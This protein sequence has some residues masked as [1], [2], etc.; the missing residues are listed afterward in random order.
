MFAIR[1]GTMSLLTTY[2]NNHAAYREDPESEDLAELHAVLSS[3]K[4]MAS[5]LCIES[6]QVI[7]DICGRFSVYNN[8]ALSRIRYNQDI[9]VTWEGDNTVLI[10]Q[11]GKYA[12]KHIQRSFKGHPVNSKVLAE[13]FIQGQEFLGI[14]CSI[15]SDFTDISDDLLNGIKYKFNYYLYKSI[16]RLQEKAEKAEN[17]MEAW[18][19]SQ[20]YYIQ[21]L[22][23]AFG[24]Y[25]MATGLFSYCKEVE[26]GCSVTGKE[27]RKVAN[28]FC[29]DRIISS[30]AIFQEK[31][32]SNNQVQL[33][34][35]LWLQLC[36]ELKDSA[37]NLIE[38]I[39][40]P[41]KLIY[42]DIGTSDGQL[43]KSIYSRL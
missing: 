40:G 20:A 12:L 28:L 35:N 16:E 19:N 34:K 13:L 37:I 6:L 8:S 17:M 7:H 10:Q 14:K 2:C 30:L 5:W 27:M 4:V 22:G 18:N 24:E 25:I 43:Y 41:D 9:N 39:S 21:E 33:L 29:L 32:M 1:A 11:V 36:R 42:S 23:K 38:S 26:A 15:R 31:Y 3:L